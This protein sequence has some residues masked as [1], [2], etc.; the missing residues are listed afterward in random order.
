ML[1]IVND[2]VHQGMI[3]ATAV[4]LLL[5]RLCCFAA[6]FLSVGAS[7]VAP[8]YVPQLAGDKYSLLQIC[9]T[10]SNF[11]H[12]LINTVKSWANII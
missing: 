3:G 1:A 2:R 9:V 5:H 7:V 6:L 10:I 11:V 4:I 8:A 12:I